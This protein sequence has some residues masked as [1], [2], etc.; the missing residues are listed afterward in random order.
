METGGKWGR[1]ELAK[2]LAMNATKATALSVVHGVI[3]QARGAHLEA[4]PKLLRFLKP[5]MLKVGI[6]A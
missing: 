1:K 2:L 4:L 3:G 5:L 6:P